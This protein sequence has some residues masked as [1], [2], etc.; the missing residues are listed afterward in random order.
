MSDSIHHVELAAEIVAAYVS[1][2]S[3]PAGE[4]PTLLGDIHSAILRI[5]M[6]GAAPAPV[7]AAKP[8]VPP[9]PRAAPREKTRAECRGRGWRS[10]SRP[11]RS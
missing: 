9:R 2:N 4:L 7:E 8:A 5:G 10:G 6:G 3:V 11:S 1:N